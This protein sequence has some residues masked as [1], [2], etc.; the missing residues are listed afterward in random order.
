MRDLNDQMK[1]EQ[2]QQQQWEEEYGHLV[3]FDKEFSMFVKTHEEENGRN[4][5]E[6]KAPF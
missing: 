5:K 6:A 2:D 4:N 3:P 1:F